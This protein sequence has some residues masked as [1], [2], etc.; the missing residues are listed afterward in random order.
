M[1]RR[2]EKGT[3]TNENFSV[4]FSSQIGAEIKRKLDIGTEKN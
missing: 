1:V 2:S 3:G 4:D